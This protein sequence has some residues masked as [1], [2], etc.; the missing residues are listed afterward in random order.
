MDTVPVAISFQT[1]RALSTTMHRPSPESWQFS[2]QMSN[3]AQSTGMCKVNSPSSEDDS[4]GCE[5]YENDP[6]FGE[7]HPACRQFNCC[8]T[9]LILLSS[10]MSCVDIRGDC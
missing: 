7:D 4:H 10:K 6:F 5:H 3:D 8:H 9:L 1:V 2:G